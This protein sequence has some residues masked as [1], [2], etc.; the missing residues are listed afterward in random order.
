MIVLLLVLVMDIS[1]GWE[2]YTI[3][4][5]PTYEACLREAKV[6]QAL[7]TDHMKRYGCLSY[8]AEQA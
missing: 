1:G 6:H 4:Q 3:A 5:Y 7:E 8:L 2:A